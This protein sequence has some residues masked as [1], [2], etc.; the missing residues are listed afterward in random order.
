MKEALEDRQSQSQRPLSLLR[1]GFILLLCLGDFSRLVGVFRRFES[2]AVSRLEY[3]T[4]WLFATTKPFS[5]GYLLL[6]TVKKVTEVNGNL[7]YLEPGFPFF[8]VPAL[9]AS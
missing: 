6:A 2:S 4:H 5:L 1:Y 3:G 7:D 8:F 9:T